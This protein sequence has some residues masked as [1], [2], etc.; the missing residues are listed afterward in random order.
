MTRERL[1]SQIYSQI[2]K[3]NH[4][5]LN[6]S[7]TKAVPGEGGIDSLLAFVGEAPGYNEDK[8]G[9]PFCGRAGELLDRLLKMISIRRD[10][11]W[12][13]NVLKCRPPENRSPLVDE[14]RACRPYLEKQLDLIKPRLIITLGRFATDHFIPE[15]KISQ[16]RGVPVR[17]GPY[18]I[19]PVYHPAAALRSE[20]V[21]REVEKDFRKIPA[22]IKADPGD[23]PQIKGV[24]ADENQATL[25]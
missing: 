19:Y 15:A 1:L 4:C 14:I 10:Q 22:L 24:R 17:V 18:F 23:F 21:L 11:V 12:I 20:E 3:C 13:G 16:V 7:R 5:R 2:L 6:R 9:V 8:Q 25:F